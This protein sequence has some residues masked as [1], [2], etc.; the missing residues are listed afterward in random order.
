MDDYK[1]ELCESRASHTLLSSLANKLEI[2][3]K[4]FVTTMISAG[5]TN[6]N[7]YFDKSDFQQMKIRL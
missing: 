4:I 2:N 6:T 3:I 1:F 5:W 7:F